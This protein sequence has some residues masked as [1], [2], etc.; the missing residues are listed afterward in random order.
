MFSR[1]KGKAS[2]VHRQGWNKLRRA[3][4]SRTAVGNGA[5]L[6]PPSKGLTGTRGKFC[7]VCWLWLWADTA[8]AGGCRSLVHKE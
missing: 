8:A 6:S 5:E 1:S 2:L 4:D 3:S 7:S